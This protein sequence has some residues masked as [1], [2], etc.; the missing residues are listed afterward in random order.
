[1]LTKLRDKQWP[2]H[3]SILKGIFTTFTMKVVL[4]TFVCRGSG[5]NALCQSLLLDLIYEKQS[6]TGV[7]WWVCPAT[8]VVVLENYL[9]ANGV[10]FLISSFKSLNFYK[11]VVE[12]NLNVWSQSPKRLFHW[13]E[14]LVEIQM[15]PFFI[16]VLFHHHPSLPSTHTRYNWKH[17]SLVG[18]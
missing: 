8:Y 1:M 9:F 10:L 5:L 11:I 7:C 6:E 15:F 14:T 3:K 12:I 18:F 13:K 16:T 17:K 2:I 4:T